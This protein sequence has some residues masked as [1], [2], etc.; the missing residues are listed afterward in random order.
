MLM[1]VLLAKVF[2]SKNTGKHIIT[3]RYSIY[4]K[5]DAEFSKY[6]AWLI[7]GYLTYF[8]RYNCYNTVVN[9]GKLNKKLNYIKTYPLN[10]KKHIYYL[11]KSLR[12]SIQKIILMHKR[13]RKY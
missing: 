10:T 13:Y 1:D 3:L 8:K 9:F 5:D 7:N 11:T 6:L 12:I 4:Q 2:E